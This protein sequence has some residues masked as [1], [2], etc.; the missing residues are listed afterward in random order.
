M[1]AGVPPPPPLAVE[2]GEFVEDGEGVTPRLGVVVGKREVEGVGEVL[3]DGDTGLSVA[4][5][6]VR[7]EGVADAGVNNTSPS[8]ALN[9]LRAIR[10]VNLIVCRARS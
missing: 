4:L 3:G 1:A 9:R 7:V 6:V 10:T 8:V 2:V 5:K